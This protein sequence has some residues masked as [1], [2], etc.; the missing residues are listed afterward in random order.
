MRAPWI[1]RVRNI[2][3][4]FTSCRNDIVDLREAV[5]PEELGDAQ[6]ATVEVA[7]H[8]DGLVLGQNWKVFGDLPHRNV[9]AAGHGAG[10]DLERLAHIEQQ[11][12]LAQQLRGGGNLDLERRIYDGPRKI[13][14]NN[15][16]VTES[17]PARAEVERGLRTRFA[18]P[19]KPVRTP[20]STKY[21]VDAGGGHQIVHHG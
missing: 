16:N 17:S 18:R 2:E 7:E 3:S 8:E 20:G 21:A 4:R 6:A 15:Q 13:G 9:P 12:A 1:C 10:R 19:A 5:G 11:R 14:R